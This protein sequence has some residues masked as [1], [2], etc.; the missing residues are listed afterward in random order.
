[1]PDGFIEDHAA[2]VAST[3]TR[4]SYQ[5]P[6]SRVTRASPYPALYGCDAVEPLR[7]SELAVLTSVQRGEYEARRSAILSGETAKGSSRRSRPYGERWRESFGSAFGGF[8]FLGSVILFPLAVLVS[9]VTFGGADTS[10]I[11]IASPLTAATYAVLL[12][13]SSALWATFKTTRSPAEQSGIDQRDSEL[14]DLYRHWRGVADR[15]RSERPGV[16]PARQL[17]NHTPA[18]AKRP[19]PIADPPSRHN[20][21]GRRAQDEAARFVGEATYSGS[22]RS[23]A[24]SNRSNPGVEFTPLL[25]DAARRELADELYESRGVVGFRGSTVR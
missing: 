14:A 18:V 1:M 21:V 23:S 19:D 10:I 12:L 24:P 22:A 17:D 3:S 11:K 4:P 7:E 8:F 2:V 6:S 25:D 20:A 5:T 16:A 9:H 13:G 15:Q